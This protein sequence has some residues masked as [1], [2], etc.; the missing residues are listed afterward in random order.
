MTAARTEINIKIFP[1]TEIKLDLFHRCQ[2]VL[3]TIEP[4]PSH[5]RCQFGKEF[6][7]IFRQ[8]N[9]LDKARTR[10]TANEEEIKANLESLLERWKNVP[11]SC[12]TS[13]KQTTYN[14]REHIKKRCLSEIPPGFGT[15]KNEQIHRLLSCSLLTGAT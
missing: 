8:R 12:L 7:L 5:L 13:E 14:L 6:C 4:G 15:E 10:D 1:D 9:D 3:R 2:R 11:S